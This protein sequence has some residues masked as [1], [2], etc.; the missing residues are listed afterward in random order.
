VK[1]KDILNHG[2]TQ[3]TQACDQAIEEVKLW[4]SQNGHCGKYNED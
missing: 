2:E 3:R 1:P 4:K